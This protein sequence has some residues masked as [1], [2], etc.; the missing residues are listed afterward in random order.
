MPNKK[1]IPGAGPTIKPTPRQTFAVKLRQASKPNVMQNKAPATFAKLMIQQMRQRGKAVGTVKIGKLYYYAYDPK[2]KDV[3]PYYDSNPVVA[4]IQFYN[5]GFLGINFHYLDPYNRAALLDRLV[6]G[7]EVG[8]NE[9][10][11]LKISYAILNGAAT[12]AAFI[13]CLHRYLY[14]HVRS[15]FLEVKRDDWALT[16]SLPLAHFKGSGQAAV[17]KQS[18]K[19][20]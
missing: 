1:S 10:A 3:L 7:Y 19:R 9:N 8:K 20:F 15:T 16:V 18:L 13:P 6:H 17:W 4:P 5:D 2:G 11:R 12:Y 14:S